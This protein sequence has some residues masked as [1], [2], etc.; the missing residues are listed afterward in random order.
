[1]V[2]FGD[3]IPSGAARAAKE[4]VRRCDLLLVVGTSASV[5]PANALPYAASNAGALVV[6]VNPSTTG[7]TG[8][9]SDGI[10][11][12][13]SSGLLQ[14]VTKALNLPPN[15]KVSDDAA[16]TQPPLVKTIKQERWC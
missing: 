4:A 16:V 6:E 14:C 5:S 13:S 1:M 12:S 10:V 7:L 8:R 2:L 15:A 3:P 9:I 11:M